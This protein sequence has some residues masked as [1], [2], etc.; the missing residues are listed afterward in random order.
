LVRDPIQV[1]TALQAGNEN[2]VALLT[3]YIGA[4]ISAQSLE[5]LAALMDERK[6]EGVAVY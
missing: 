2:A 3:G 6:C 5:N 1:L 4:V